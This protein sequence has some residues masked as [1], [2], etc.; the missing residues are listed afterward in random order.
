MIF[1]A[2]EFGARITSCANPAQSEFPYFIQCPDRICSDDPRP[3]I[4]RFFNFGNDVLPMRSPRAHLPA[5]L[6]V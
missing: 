5:R 3:C 4:Q 1:S 6:P 2:A